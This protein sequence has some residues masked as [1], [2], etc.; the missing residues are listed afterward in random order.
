MDEVIQEVA[1]AQVELD[2]LQP[3]KDLGDLEGLKRSIQRYGILQPPV[4][5]PA[6]PDHYR[7]LA[8]ERRVTAARELGL[9]HLTVIIRTVDDHERRYLQLVEN[10]QREDLDP[11]EQADTFRQL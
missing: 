9:S 2:P 11:F 7:L 5:T 1:I 3:R 4:V 10:L 6:G 8:G